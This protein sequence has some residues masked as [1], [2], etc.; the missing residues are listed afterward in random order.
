[1]VLGISRDTKGV[2]YIKDTIGVRC[3][4]GHKKY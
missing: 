2:R 4:K 1:M 3:I